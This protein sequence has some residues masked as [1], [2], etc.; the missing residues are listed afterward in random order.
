MGMHVIKMPDVGEGIAEV[1]LV[2]WHVKPGDA[3]AEDQVLADV[4]TDKATVEIPSP[5]A[6]KVLA[7]GGEVGAGDGG[8]RRADPDRGRRRGQRQ[9]KPPAARAGRGRGGADGTAAP[10]VAAA[11]PA[12]AE[13][14]RRRPPRRRRRPQ[15]PSRAR[16]R[17]PAR[18]SASRRPGDKPIA[19]PAVR[20]RAWELGIDLQFVPRQRPGRPHH[21]RGPRRVR[22]ARA[23]AAGAA[24]GA[25]ATPSAPTRTS[26]PGHRPAPQDRAEDAGGQAPHPAL[27]LCRGNRRH[28]ARGRCAR[29]STRSGAPSAARLTLLPFLMRAMVLAVREF[30]QINARFDDDGGRRHA[31]TAR[32][33]SASPR[34]P[35]RGLMVPVVRHAEARDLWAMR[36]RGRAPRRG[37]AQRP[38]RRARSC[39]STITI[40]SLGALGGIVTTPVI[41]HPEVA[42]VGVNRIVRAAGDARRRGRAAADDEPVVVLRPPRGRRRR[43]GASSCRRCAACW[44]ARRRCSWRLSR[45]TTRSTDPARHRRRPRR[46]CRR[47]PRR[48]SSASTPSLVEGEQLGGTCLNVGCIPS[49]ALIHAAERVREGPPLRA[50]TRRSA[51]G[52]SRRASTSRRPCAGRTASSRG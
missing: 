18:R 22:G 3:V 32:C 15:P 50:A 34:R 43:R 23:R 25:G 14:Q 36:R 27:H 38:G 35:T 4:M 24:R 12:A 48:R 40:T 1:E 51:S 10:A 49:K 47:H 39:G 29:G 2:A 8:R 31:A 42:I 9:A 37:G 5:V 20:R 44:N 46:L 16:R 33:T 45:W 28:R 17:A 13:R 30:P 41:N 21:A 6:G 7:L 19:S 11:A 26:D 52:S